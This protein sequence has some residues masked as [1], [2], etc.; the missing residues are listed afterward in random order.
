MAENLLEKTSTTAGNG[1]QGHSQTIVSYNPATE[2][3]IGEVVCATPEDIEIAMQK[4]RDSQFAWSQRPLD[5]RLKISREIQ[6]G[7]YRRFDE[8]ADLITAEQG[9]VK[10]E[11]VQELL[12]QMELISF[13]CRNAKKVL[14]PRRPLVKLVP[15]RR[16]VIERRP[17]G[18]VLVISPWN[19]PILL[20]Y[21]PAL[22]A[23]IAGNSVILK[24][25]EYTPLVAQVIGEIVHEAGVPK[26]VFQVLHGTGKEVG[27]ALLEAKP[28]A[29]C[30]TGSEYTG[31]KIAARAGELL[32]PVILELGGK[33]AAIVLEDANIDRT[34]RGLMWGNIYNSG[35]MCLSVERVF[36]MRSVADEFVETLKMTM[37]KYVNPSAPDK[38]TSTNGPITNKV[39]LD[40]IKRHVQEAV[41]TKA[42][43]VQSKSDNGQFFPATI[44]MGAAENLEVADEETFGPVMN[45][46]LIDDEQEAIKKV[47][48]SRFGLT[49][50]IWTE[51]KKRALNIAKQLH[52]GVISVNDHIWS[53]AAPEMPWGGVKASGY[54]RTRGR[55][56]LVDMTTAHAVSYERIRLPWEPFM[57]PYTKLKRVALR[58]F[59]DF[60]YGI[61]WRDKLSAFFPRF[62]K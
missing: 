49:A 6:R 8:L 56:G 45:L 48:A 21:T 18:V 43:V 32:I 60:W 36:V 46:I 57:L 9:K 47:N 54:G 35:Q 44:I 59:I 39:Q 40:I 42:T 27:A 58:R 23:L 11:S 62:K 7:I 55:E 4:A 14:K 10:Q 53:T 2:E 34:A 12:A 1:H 3:P 29:V 13:Y 24:P 5:E 19:F 52:V 61:T 15:H 16:H 41:D 20:G 38:P 22:T 28:N 25:S 51:N 30:F 50:S 37:E 31:R 26:E 33:D 17:H